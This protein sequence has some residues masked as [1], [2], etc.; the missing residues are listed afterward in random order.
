MSGAAFCIPVISQ[1]VP[2]INIKTIHRRR[3]TVSSQC[4]G[5]AHPLTF[6]PGWCKI[7]C[8]YNAWNMVQVHWTAV[9]PSCFIAERKIFLRVKHFLQ[10]QI[11]TAHCL[12]FYNYLYGPSS[13]NFSFMLI[14]KRQK[15]SKFLKFCFLRIVFIKHRRCLA[16]WSSRFAFHCIGIYVLIYTLSRP[17]GNWLY[18]HRF[19]CLG[20]LLTKWNFPVSTDTNFVGDSVAV[21]E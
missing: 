9:V 17:T 3:C 18:C 11:T 10:V 20:L 6:R 14:L 1:S 16:F 4:S 12:G 5:H 19:L 2:H 15:H 13:S 21:E 8:R 7:L